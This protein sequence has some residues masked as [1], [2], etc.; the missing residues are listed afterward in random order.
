MN[1]QR[2]RPK[3]Y[4]TIVSPEPRNNYQIDIIVYDRY[5][6]HHYKYIL[7]CIDVYSRFA[8]ARAMT[9]RDMPTIMKNVKDIF[10]EM[11]NPKNINAD[12]EFNKTEFNKYCSDNKINTYFSQPDEI[13]KNAIV[14]RFNRT[15][16]GLIQKWRIATGKYN[17][18]SVL[19]K[20]INNYNN[21][22]HR[23]IKGKPIDLFTGKA[24]TSQIP[25]NIK[26]K[27]KVGDIVRVRI[28]KKIF[29]KGDIITYS[30]E[31]YVIHAIN[32][33]K[34]QLQN[35]KGTVLKRQYKDYE[36]SKITSIS[37]YTPPQEEEKEHKENQRTKKIT[38]NTKK[39][40]VNN[41][42]IQTRLRTR[43]PANQLQSA[44]YGRI[45]W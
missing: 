34:F 44:K 22:Y 16:A 31:T 28:D 8:S 18:Y 4:R 37:S 45:N 5:E 43:Q 20:L 13:N 19:G 40:G 39:E 26:K 3:T 15:L 41:T 35:A 21:T 11:G 33:N 25:N 32:K 9:K 14:E 23:T 42:N 10:Q 38:R 27:L 1:K 6:F 7:C 17:W 2:R 30:K 36:L 12:N 29:D 24:F